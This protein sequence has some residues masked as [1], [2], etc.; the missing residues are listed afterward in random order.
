MKNW[1]TIFL[2]GCVFSMYIFPF[3]FTFLPIGNTKIFIAVWGLVLWGANLVGR[4]ESLV[5][6]SMV[7]V[8][9]WAFGISL[10]SVISLAYNGATDTAYVSYLVS[11]WVWVGAAYL[12]CHLIKSV[13]GRISVELICWYF[14]G[15]C[16]A[17]CLFAILNEFVPVFRAVVN[18]LVIQ[19]SQEYLEDVER[20]YGI[21]A[22]FD[23]AGSRFACSL[24]M[25]SFLFS[26]QIRRTYDA[27][28]VALFSLLFIW[29]GIV[30]NMV[31]RT[32]SAGLL[33]AV[34]F[35]LIDTKVFSF[36][37]RS[38]YAKSLYVLLGLMI[39]L[40][41]IGLSLYKI[42][43]VENLFRFAF[44]MLFN[45]A[46]SG[47]LQTGSTDVLLEMWRHYPRDFKT[48]II[49]DGY[50]ISP[51][52]TNP[53]YVG[54]HQ[55]A[56]YMGVDVGYLRFIYYF[57]LIGLLCFVCYMFVTAKE[58][59]NN[60]PQYKALFIMLLI[61]NYVLWAKVA[62]DLFCVFAL[63]LML[64]PSIQEEEPNTNLTTVE[65]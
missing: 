43:A 54:N 37:V 25:L 39:V 9:L 22:A 7:K 51:T 31:A 40:I 3:T 53:Y 35:L 38:S 21:G 19:Q 11:M 44:E 10:I 17:Q 50:F 57:G 64:D 59:M 36:R 12:V 45:L 46:D 52:A 1:I 30:G 23:T 28:V 55:Y 48:W 32:T 18:S 61:M 8:S 33:I 60:N 27:K 47:E 65:Q 2:V 29:I 5:S 41:P 6:K 16:A 26:Q 56:Y 24:I 34:V 62:T 4:R 15:V 13:H 58:C 42:P 49:G 14:I 20:M 63:F